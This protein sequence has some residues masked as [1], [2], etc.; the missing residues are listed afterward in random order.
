MMSYHEVRRALARMKRGCAKHAISS[1][2]SNGR[3]G[4]VRR[5]K[6]SVHGQKH[7]TTTVA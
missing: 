7:V 1:M 5:V 3:Y 6:P 4:T 2:S